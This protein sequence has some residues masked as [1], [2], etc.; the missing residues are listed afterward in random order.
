MNTNDAIPVWQRQLREAAEKLE[1]IR[2][3]TMRKREQDLD[4]QDT[5]PPNPEI[6]NT[7][8]GK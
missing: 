1:A 4:W 6:K 3:E 7:S 2:Q 5:Q 8:I